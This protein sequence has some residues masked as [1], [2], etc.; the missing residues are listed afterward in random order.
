[1][2]IDNAQICLTI[3]P[4]DTL[5]L[6]SSLYDTLFLYY[7]RE[8]GVWEMIHS[9]VGIFA[10]QYELTSVDDNFPYVEF[11]MTLERRP[12]YY[13]L[14]FILPC[15]YMVCIEFLILNNNYLI[16]TYLYIYSSIFS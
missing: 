16:C 3:F 8:H 12:S 14:N 6:L 1:M 15:I 13:T 2:P 5:N 11:A 9:E 10:A 7:F 4:I